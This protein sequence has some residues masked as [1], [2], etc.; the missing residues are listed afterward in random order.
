MVELVKSGERVAADGKV[1]QTQASETRKEE[2]REQ[3]I[4]ECRE[5][6]TEF[7]ACLATFCEK[8]GI[9]VRMNSRQRITRKRCSSEVNGRIAEMTNRGNSCEFPKKIVFLKK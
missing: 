1:R 3:L 7:K 2:T 9:T 5:L 6:I 4:E 8:N